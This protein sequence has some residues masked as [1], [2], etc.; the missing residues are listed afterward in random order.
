MS[1]SS[2][3]KS[4]TAIRGKRDILVSRAGGDDLLDE[5]FHSLDSL[6]QSAD[7]EYADTI[8]RQ[9]KEIK[10][11]KK[12]SDDMLLN[13][14]QSAGRIEEEA[15][16]KGFNAGKEAALAEEKVKIQ[17]KL[18][19]FD[20][21]L[22]GLSGDR[23]RVHQ[24]YERD[25]V[26]M[27]KVMVDRVLFHEVTVNPL[28]IQVCLEKAMSYIV[29]NSN[30]K[31]HL[32]GNDFKRLREASMEKPE[33]LSGANQVELTEDPTISE[34]GCFIE[35]EFGEVNMTLETRK[36]KLYETIDQVFLTALSGQKG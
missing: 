18:V 24:E 6:W 32:H 9:D 5:Q 21:I 17:E 13:A 23:E 14:K 31:V 16:E 1:L 28:A 20:R 7:K 2:I 36:E 29:E 34:G 12:Q 3:I 19:E 26:N 11:A 27:V 22:N 15:Y 8:T 33:L 10:L 4:P 35:T 25:I 30:M